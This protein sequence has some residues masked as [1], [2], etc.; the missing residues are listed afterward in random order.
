MTATASYA[1]PPGV[2]SVP[3]AGTGLPGGLTPADT[4]G[5]LCLLLKLR[6]VGRLYHAALPS[7]AVVSLP[8]VTVWITPHELYWQQDGQR[9][10]CPV[11]GLPAAAGHLAC[12]ARQADP[13]DAVGRAS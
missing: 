7:R 4:A 5:E 3:Q 9:M 6:D 10:T 2:A 13:A 11:E 8:G 12:L 1:L